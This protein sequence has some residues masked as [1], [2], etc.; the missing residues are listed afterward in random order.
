M[1]KDPGRLKTF[2]EEWQKLPG[3]EFLHLSWGSKKNV[4]LTITDCSSGYRS[5]FI[6]S[7]PIKPRDHEPVLLYKNEKTSLPLVNKID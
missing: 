5:T 3:A 6:F 4:Q 2:P 1:S 7:K